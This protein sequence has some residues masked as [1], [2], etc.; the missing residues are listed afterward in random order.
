LGRTIRNDRPGALKF[1]R[2]QRAQGTN[3]GLALFM[4]AEY[5]HVRLGLADRVENG[6][7]KALGRAPTSF[8]EFAER[9]RHAW[10][11]T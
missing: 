2:E 10:T 5:T 3:R 8:R 9:E 11:T 6:V 7:Q 4:V 1:Y